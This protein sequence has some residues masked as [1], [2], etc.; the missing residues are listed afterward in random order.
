MNPEVLS[1]KE[2]ERIKYWAKRIC[3]YPGDIYGQEE[4]EDLQRVLDYEKLKNNKAVQ[5]KLERYMA[6]RFA[7]DFREERACTNV[8][9][10]LIRDYGEA[11]PAE[12]ALINFILRRLANTTLA[13][14]LP[15]LKKS[16]G[17]T[18][19]PDEPRAKQSRKRRRSQ[20]SRKSK[21]IPFR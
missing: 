10:E 21:I 17:E 18:S 19:P 5:K 9:V 6:K 15:P 13:S 12:R 7:H 14:L 1:E 11:T 20:G 2:Q 8:F 4:E 16:S 3:M